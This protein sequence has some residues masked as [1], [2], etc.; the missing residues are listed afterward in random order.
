MRT[1]MSGGVT[2]KAGDSL[3]MSMLLVSTIVLISLRPNSYRKSQ[4]VTYTIR[5]RQQI[6]AGGHHEFRSQISSAWRASSVLVSIFGKRWCHLVRRNARDRR[7]RFDA[8]H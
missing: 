2:G 1:R 8:Q 6:Y 3:P 7:R 4:V 5:V